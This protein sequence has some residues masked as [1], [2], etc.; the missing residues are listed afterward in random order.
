MRSVAKTGKMPSMAARKAAS[1]KTLS[2]SCS[3]SS[4][5]SWGEKSSAGFV[6]V[7]V[8]QLQA[9]TQKDDGGDADAL[10]VHEDQVAP[11]SEDSLIEYN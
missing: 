5:C 6:T 10:D 7:L 9:K 1:D 4:S 11:D 2:F 8:Y 3:S